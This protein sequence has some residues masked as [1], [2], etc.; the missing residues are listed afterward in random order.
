M[1]AMETTTTS[2]AIV[3]GVD[4]SEGGRRALRW[5]LDE[6]ARCGDTVRAVTAWQWAGAEAM[7]PV[8]VNPDQQRQQTDAMLATEIA[9][10][11]DDLGDPRPVTGTV[12]EGLPGPVLADA[13]RTARLLVIGSHGH[14]RL[15]HAVLGSVMQ[16]C[17]RR[18]PCP[19]VVVP[20]PH[21]D[22]SHRPA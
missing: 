2:N 9:D 1:N 16:E 20:V 11:L 19:V 8:A 13:A 15:F 17:V 21:P 4:G 14:S 3:V 6:A 7:A 5:A 10:V 18:A 12:T 22:R